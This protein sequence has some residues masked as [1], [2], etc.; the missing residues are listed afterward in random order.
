MGE[1]GTLVIADRLCQMGGLSGGTTST[2]SSS[3]S[4]LPTAVLP[5]YTDGR[6]VMAGLEIYN[7]IGTGEAEVTVIYTNQA[8]VANR[9]GKVPQLGGDGYRLPGRVIPI[10]L[11]SGDRGVRS[12]QTVSLNTSTGAIGNFGV[13][14]FKPLITVGIPDP[15]VPHY[16]DC[17]TGFDGEIPEIKTNAC[18]WAL[19]IS[20]GTSSGAI[21]VN[22]KFGEE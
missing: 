6:G 2:Q 3:N 16:F 11:S 10:Y 14:L 15:N 13:T 1:P 22:F 4:N 12:V 18:L 7:T 21:Q 20:S 19:F 8:G 5:R 17:I 9:S